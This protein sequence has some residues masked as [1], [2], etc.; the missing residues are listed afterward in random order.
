MKCPYM[1]GTYMFSCVARKDV[2]I[3]SFFEFSEYC[4]SVRYE[5]FKVCPFYM[6][7][8]I[9]SPVRPAAGGRQSQLGR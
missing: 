6:E 3:P 8:Q 7:R 1:T 5:R 9:G 2:Y 4:S